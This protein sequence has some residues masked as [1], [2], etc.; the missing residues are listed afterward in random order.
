MAIYSTFFL[1]NPG[2][3]TDIFPEWK[4]PLDEPVTRQIINPFTNEEESITTRAPEWEDFDPSEMEF[5]EPEV[6]IVDGD[7]QTFLEGRIPSPI[8][9]KSHLCLKDLTN[10]ELEPLVAATLNQEKASLETALYAHPMDSSALMQFPEDFLSQIQSSSDSDLNGIAVKWAK[11]MSTPDYTHSMDGQRLSEDWT[12]EDA[13]SILAPIITL[14][15][16]QTDNQVMYL[17]LEY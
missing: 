14:I 15:K 10:V 17:L 4:L 3:L 13:S 5:P 6:E 16:K 2:E 9:A 11:I 7:Y 12:T 1:S 8:Q